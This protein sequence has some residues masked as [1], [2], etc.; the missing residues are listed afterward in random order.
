M[1]PLEGTKVVDMTRFAAGPFA[2][3]QL[4]DMGAEVIKVEPPGK[5]DDLRQWGPPFIGGEG[6]YYMLLNKNKKSI[7]VN[8]RAPEGVDIVRRLLKNA[9]VL[10]ENFRPGVM[11]RMGLSYE[12]VHALNPKLIYCSISGYGQKGP[13][14]DKPGFD[15]MIQAESG[16]MDITGFDV[17]TRVGIAIADLVGGLY[18]AQGILTALIAREKTGEGQH[19]DI[20]LLDSLASLL[21]YQAGIYIATGESPTRKGNRHPLSTP[22]EDFATEDGHVIIAAGNQR[23]W[24]TLCTKVLMQ[25]DLITDPRFLT[26]ADRNTNEPALKQIIEGITSRKTTDE[27]IKLL[28]QEGIPCG[29]IRKV[30]EVLESENTKAREMMVEAEDPARGKVKL[31]GIPVKLSNTPGDIRLMPPLLGQHTEEVLKE[32]GYSKEEVKELKS[33]GIV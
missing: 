17:P 28:E 29:R 27:W 33:R 22:Y 2:A 11:D 1:R 9:D 14:W 4:A 7:T 23:L 5:G 25:P 19:V 12:T 8:T 18:G 13:L 32:L 24:E 31:L 21:S 16:F 10:L 6:V 30:G 15:V 3:M 26:M 20:A